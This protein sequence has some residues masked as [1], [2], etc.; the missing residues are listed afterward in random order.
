MI[1]FGE[2]EDPRRRVLIEALTL[3]LLSAA[4]PARQAL[5]DELFGRTPAKLP[6]GQSIYRIS[7]TATVN[8]VAATL[9]TPI[10]ANDTVATGPDS[11]IIFV[12]G[13]NSMI[14]RSNSHLELST[15]KESKDSFLIGGLRLI[16]G[17]ILSVS[18]SNGL[19]LRTP[20]ATI[21]IRG[22]GVYMETD[23]ERTYF[24]TCYG[25]SDTTAIADPESKETVVATHH[26]HPLYI[27]ANAPAG[28][29]IRRAPFINHTDQELALIE[30][31]VGR[32]PPW[33]F[34]GSLYNSPRRQY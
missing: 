28:A 5:G 25:I 16:Q 11:E 19:A 13:G 24:C 17:A 30:T 29:S 2:A 10:K 3:G 15:A 4:L 33:T 20:T 23:P 12:V 21:G 34:P 32:T 8:N 26:D 7:G 27:L 31:L 18:R 1:R 14:L 22:T 9:Q 6:E